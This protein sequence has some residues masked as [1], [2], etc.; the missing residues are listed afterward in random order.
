VRLLLDTHALIW[1]ALGSPRMSATARSA[2]ESLDNDVIVSAASAWEL[3]T[4][5]RIGKLPVAAKF[6]VEF[7][8]KV[9]GLGFQELAVTVEHGQRAGLLTG[10]HKDPFDRMLIA[11]AL[12]ENLEIVSNEQVFDE[13]HVR[14]IW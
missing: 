2:I 9:R 12:T 3:T 1:F 11:Q 10:A 14:R 4:K 6:A 5:V 8:E 7:R 13:Y